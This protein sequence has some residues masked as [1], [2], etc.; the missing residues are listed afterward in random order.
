MS[1]TRREELIAAA[2]RVGIPEA[3]RRID[4]ALQEL[5]PPT[6]DLGYHAELLAAHAMSKT[7][8]GQ[9]MS[10][11]NLRILARAAL[12]ALADQF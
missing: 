10:T 11:D 9:G 4:A 5:P 2:E 7:V 1:Q 12:R 8:A 6:T 3:E